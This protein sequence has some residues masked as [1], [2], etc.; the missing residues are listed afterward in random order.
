PVE[1]TALGNAIVQ[2]IKLGELGSIDQARELLSRTVETGQFEPK[3]PE[4]WDTAYER[5]QTII[6]TV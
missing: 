6:T 4:S 5:F 3:F 1:A 2:L